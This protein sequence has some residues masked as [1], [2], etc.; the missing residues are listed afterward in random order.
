MTV[1]TAGI[2]SSYS[3]FWALPTTLLTG[4]AASAGIALVNSIGN[5]A[6]YFGPWLVGMLRQKTNSMTAPM[7]L[8]SLCC[9]ASALLTAI[10]FRESKPRV[11]AAEAQKA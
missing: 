9:L 2:A 8:L 3:T 1:A 6:G 10:V 11:V 7:L 4:T 5:L